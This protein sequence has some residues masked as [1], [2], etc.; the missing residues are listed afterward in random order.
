MGCQNEPEAC[1]SHELSLQHLRHSQV[2]NGDR[3]L[4]M[5]AEGH[6]VLMEAGQSSSVWQEILTEWLGVHASRIRADL[7]R[8][9]HY[10]YRNLQQGEEQH[11]VQEEHPHR[12]LLRKRV[13]LQALH[14]QI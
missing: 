4:R 7:C 9:C 5:A 13:D 10:L 8:T 2:P 14:S 11:G 12:S 3:Q 6:R 1:M